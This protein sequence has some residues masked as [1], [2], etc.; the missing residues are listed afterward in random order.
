MCLEP[1]HYFFTFVEAA[2][3][4]CSCQNTNGQICFA[5]K[6]VQLPRIVANRKFISGLQQ[7]I[8]LAFCVVF[9]SNGQIQLLHIQLKLKFTELISLKGFEN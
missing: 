6:T 8:L 3:F 1:F 2:N 5:F 4:Y 9:S 7:C